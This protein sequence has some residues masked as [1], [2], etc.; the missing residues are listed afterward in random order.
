MFVG[1]PQHLRAVIASWRAA[2]ER[3]HAVGEVAVHFFDIGLTARVEP[4]IKSRCRL[5]ILIDRANPRHLAIESQPR[6]LRWLH[7]AGI[8]ALTNRQRSGLIEI[9]H[10]LFH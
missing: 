9:A 2:R 3:C 7:S 1:P 4:G 6:Y 10:L 8:H 5:E